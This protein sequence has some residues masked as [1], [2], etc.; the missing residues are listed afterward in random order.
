MSEQQQHGSA[1]RADFTESRV[2]SLEVA[3]AT[4]ADDIERLQRALGDERATVDEL[5]LKLRRTHERRASTEQIARALICE[6]R[7]TPNVG[8]ELLAASRAALAALAKLDRGE[9]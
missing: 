4:L 8:E 9:V 1:P 3:R 7:A 5:K 6:V 2:R